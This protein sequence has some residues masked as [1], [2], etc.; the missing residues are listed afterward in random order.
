MRKSGNF[1]SCAEMKIS[2]SCKVTVMEIRYMEVGPIQTNC[3]ILHD[4]KQGVCAIIDP[5][6]E[7]RRIFAA[8]KS[9]ENCTPVAILLT[10]GHY[11]HT[12][13]VAGLREYWPGIPVYL[14]RRDVFR[15]GRPVSIFPFVPDTLDYDEGDTVTIGGLTVQ[16]LATP[17]HSRGSVSLLC[18]D[19]L[20]S[21]DTMFAGDCGRTDLYGGNMQVMMESLRRLGELPGDM[22]VLPGHM[23]LS[24]LE[25]E[26]RQNPWLRQAMGTLH[27]NSPD[28]TD[29]KPI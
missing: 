8:V 12:G 29:S 24:T 16:V 3:Y 20:F 18:E 21:G 11:D 19:A 28:G 9:I 10:H 5:G 7:E 1:H 2:H 23:G 4:E 17:G 6:D 13:A 22:R 26:R 27:Q 15:S 14:N 25:T